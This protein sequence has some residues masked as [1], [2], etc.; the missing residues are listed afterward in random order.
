MGSKYAHGKSSGVE[1]SGSAG[2]PVHEIVLDLAKAQKAVADAISFWCD[3]DDVSLLT[4]VH[5]AEDV[6]RRLLATAS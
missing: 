6:V 4:R 3:P 1:P 2:A 5:L